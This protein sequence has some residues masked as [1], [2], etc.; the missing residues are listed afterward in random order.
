MCIRDSYYT[1]AMVEATLRLEGV[2]EERKTIHARYGLG[3]ALV[4]WRTVGFKKIKFYSLESLG[5]AA[6]ELPA[7][8]LPTVTL[9]VA[10][11]GTVMAEVAGQGFNPYE[12]LV[13][14]KNAVA[15]VIPLFSMCDPRDVRGVMDSSNLDVAAAFIYDV[16][17]GGLGYAENAYHRLD[18]VLAAAA[19]LIAGCECRDGCPSCVG[20]AT[21]FPN[22]VVDPDLRPGHYLPHKAAALSLLRCL[23]R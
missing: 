13:G 21:Y 15:A 3:E 22:Q 17:P 14:L 19:E 16:Y 20:V 6:L 4:S 11:E 10:P 23:R 5:W 18:E 1:Q 12:V 8:E 2:L 9:F 7:V